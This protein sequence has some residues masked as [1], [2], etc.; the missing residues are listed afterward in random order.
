M[1]QGTPKPPS[2]N[3]RDLRLSKNLRG[4]AGELDRLLERGAGGPVLFSLIVWNSKAGSRVQYVANVTRP[5]A[6]K[7]L[8]ELLARWKEG[9]PDVPAHEVQ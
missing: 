4:I 5:D 6:T 7:G 1:S 3:D 8:E 2:G 9:M